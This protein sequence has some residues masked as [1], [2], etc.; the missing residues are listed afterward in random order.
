MSAEQRWNTL[1]DALTL[2]LPRL[3]LFDWL[4]LY[5]GD[6]F[7]QLIQEPDDIVCHAVGDRLPAFV[8]RVDTKKLQ[9]L[10]W[11]PPAADM[12]P[13]HWWITQRWPLSHDDARRVAT[14]IVATLRQVYAAAD[15][16]QVQYRAVNGPT[17]QPWDATYLG[18]SA[19]P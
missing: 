18:L 14:L 1:V 17:S 8:G 15:P 12:D 9:Q 19:R 5:C 6:M 10:G 11:N 2:G 3:A 13:P 7:V 4:A 16:D